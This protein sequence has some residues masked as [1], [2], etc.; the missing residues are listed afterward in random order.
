[1]D[2]PPR[3]MQCKRKEKRGLNGNW[4]R[5]PCVR[6]PVEIQLVFFVF[7][8][9]VTFC[10]RWRRTVSFRRNLGSLH[11]RIFAFGVELD[12]YLESKSREIVKLS[13]RSRPSL[14]VFPEV[15]LGKRISAVFFVYMWHSPDYTKMV[16]QSGWA[17]GSA[18]LGSVCIS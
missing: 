10:A 4:S 15:R 16:Y 1:V 12:L 18:M 8:L 6:V 17:K 7:F 5:C 2:E 13:G 3:I 11:G 9:S 14:L